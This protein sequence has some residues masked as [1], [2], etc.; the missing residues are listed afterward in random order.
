MSNHTT[1]VK[2]HAKRVKIRV[3][4]HISRKVERHLRAAYDRLVKLERTA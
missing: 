3:L 1:L 2:I 4:L